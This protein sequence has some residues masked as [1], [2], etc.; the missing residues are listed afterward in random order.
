MRLHAPS[1]PVAFFPALALLL[2][3]GLTACAPQVSMDVLEPAAAHGVTQ[4][5]R[6]AVVQFNNDEGGIA[7]AAVEQALSSFTLGQQP[8]FTLVDAGIL[9]NYLGGQGVEMVFDT[10][11]LRKRNK[12]IGADGVVLGTVSRSSWRDERTT[13]QRYVCVDWGKNGSCRKY[14]SRDVPCTTRTGL[15]SFTPKVVE[16]SSGKI[17]FSQEFAESDKEDFCRGTD[18]PQPSGISLVEN[19][20]KSA[21][22]R[23]LRVVAPHVV[24]VQVPLITTDDSGMDK[25]TRDAIAKG[26]DFAQAGRMDRACA[27]WSAAEA[28]HTGGYALPYLRGVCAEQAGNL[29][30]AEAAYRQADQH[31]ASP[32]SEISN[33]LERIER[34]KANSRLLEQQLN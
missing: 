15:F 10:K 32:N 16:V 14:G 31:C 17:I 2:V 24:R 5:R 18:D 1:H 13:K 22:Q 9:E 34:A 7:T 33:A 4:L 25:P 27:A 21:I 29:D 6:L 26:V 28:S 12:G 20:R 23:F 8:Y 3:L 19:A 30:L 11:E